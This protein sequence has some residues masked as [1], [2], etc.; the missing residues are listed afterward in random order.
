[1]RSALSATVQTRPEIAVV[2]FKRDLRLQDHQPL[3]NAI[4]SG[5]PTILLYVFEP[6]LMADEHYSERHW[7]FVTQSLQ[8][9]NRGLRLSPKRPSLAR[10][11]VAHCAVLEAL[12][13]LNQ[14]FQITALFSHEET[15]LD[16]TFTRDKVVARYCNAHRITWR[17]SVKDAVQRGAK[18]RRTWDQE[19]QKHMLSHQVHID[20]NLLKVVHHRF[21]TSAL[22]NAWKQFDPAMQCGGSTA[23]N[24]TLSSFLQD[25]GKHYQF[26]ISKPSKAQLSCSRMSPYLAWGNISLRQLYQ[27]TLAHR[28]KPA[29]KRALTSF[30]SRLH[31]HC[32]FIQKFESEAI[33]EF[34]PINRGYDQ[35]PFKSVDHTSPELMAWKTGHTGYPLVDACVRCLIKTGYLNFRMRAMLVSFLSH[36]LQIDWRMGV[37]HLASLF[38]DFEP[39]IHYA[40]F[41]MQAGVTG[42]N[43]L[44]IYN[45]TKQAHEHDADGVFILQWCPELH[46]LPKALIYEPWLL[47]PMDEILYDFIIGKTY[48]LPIVDLN[49][50][51]THSRDLLWKWRKRPEVMRES[52]RILATHVRERS[53]HG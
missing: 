21:N 34:H 33:M 16:L 28:Q 6:E 19:W 5:L 44:R 3:A 4:E 1:M 7:R 23:A 32:H 14:H 10:V 25:R 36:H 29:W 49:H 50:S 43:T 52:R 42:I 9:M 24:A 41:Q 45:P 15:G 13:E 46:A 39:G 17:E 18:N 30:S 22:P 38:L 26:N 8:D 20:I 12:N 47:T 27:T 40:Q 51:Y 2:W 48:P 31:W 11:S 53:R 37:K 35:F